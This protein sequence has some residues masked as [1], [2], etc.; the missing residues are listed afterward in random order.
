MLSIQAKIEVTKVQ[1]PYSRR[2]QNI[3]MLWVVV[4]VANL[5]MQAAT[6]IR[7]MCTK[8]LNI[9]YFGYKLLP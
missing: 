7:V 9:K 3:L 8:Y 5:V 1:D 6:P 2:F 4:Q